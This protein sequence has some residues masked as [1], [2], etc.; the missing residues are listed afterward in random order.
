LPRDDGRQRP[1]GERPVVRCLVARPRSR[2]NV[3][4]VE[5]VSL[6]DA[7]RRQREGWYVVGPD[8]QDMIDL[9]QWE[10]AQRG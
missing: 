2:G 9:A 10:K 4:D 5:L 3:S 6:E 1:E 8:P 7:Y